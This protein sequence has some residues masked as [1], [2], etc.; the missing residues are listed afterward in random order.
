MAIGAKTIFT[1]N[2]RGSPGCTHSIY[3]GEPHNA[4]PM[5]NNAFED[6]REKESKSRTKWENT[7]DGRSKVGKACIRAGFCG[8]KRLEVFL[9]PPGWNA[10]PSQG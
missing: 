5:L 8:M 7:L 1:V 9:L 3:M 10:S 2:L 4:Y 6:A